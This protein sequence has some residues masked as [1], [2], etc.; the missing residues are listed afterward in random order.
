M[1]ANVIDLRQY[2]A[3]HRALAGGQVFRAKIVP[4]F[5]THGVITT[6]MGNDAIAQAAIDLAVR[7]P[8]AQGGRRMFYGGYPITPSSETL[9]K[10]AAEIGAVGGAFIQF[11]DEIASILAIIGASAGGARA[12]TATSGPGFSLMQEGIGLACLNGVPIVVVNVQRSGPSTGSPTKVGQADLLQA[13]H[14]THG[15]HPIIV[16]A[17]NSPQECYDEMLRAFYLSDKYSTPVILLSDATVGQMKEPVVLPPTG[18]IPVGLR[19]T[20]LGTH[21][22]GLHS[23]P[24]GMPTKQRPVVRAQMD[25]I[26]DRLTTPEAQAEILKIDSFM[27]EDPERDDMIRGK[28]E[29]VVIAF[30]IAARSAEEAVVMARRGNVKAGLLRPVTIWPLDEKSIMAALANA[31]KVVVPELNRGQLIGLIERVAFK[32]AREYGKVPPEIVGINRYDTAQIT[33]GEILK[34]I[35]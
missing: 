31:R 5:R 11:E 14:G 13:I 22:T 25:Q 35:S 17:P 6:M 3:V 8:L 28:A 1:V 26:F 16:L 34:E 24:N 12:F 7:D 27:I 30:G 21:I 10:I 4:A 23:G 19:P 32:M 20:R 9:H 18:I 2:N 29:V 15:D 33:P